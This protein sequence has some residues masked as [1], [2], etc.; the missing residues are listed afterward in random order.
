MFI[1]QSVPHLILKAFN[2][3]VRNVYSHCRG[4]FGSISLTSGFW[5]S[6][7]KCDVGAFCADLKAYSS[8]SQ[9]N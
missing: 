5:A 2:N 7:I 3:T 8:A 4:C 9:L 6:L 1:F